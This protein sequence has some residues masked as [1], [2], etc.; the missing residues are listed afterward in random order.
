ML[1][2]FKL[3]KEA[4]LPTRHHNTDAGADIF[5]LEDVFIPHGE[6]RKVPTGVAILIEEGKV[7]KLETRSSYAAKALSVRGGVIDAGYNGEVS[8]ML[9]NSGFTDHQELA[10]WKRGYQV[11]R[12]D[13]VAQLIVYDVHTSPIEE[14]GELW[15]SE[16][17]NKGFGS[18][19]R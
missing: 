7:G 16:R 10:T 13:K 9:H 5:A 6:T 4:I 15:S 2:V 18:S 8:V 1:K 11:K 3:N 19:G 17:S 14:V 12:G